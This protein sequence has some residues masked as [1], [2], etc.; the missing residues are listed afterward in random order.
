MKLDT[1]ILCAYVGVKLRHFNH[2][3]DHCNQ[4]QIQES[5]L[6]TFKNI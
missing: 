6:P 5:E 2:I 4:S 3:E 1:A